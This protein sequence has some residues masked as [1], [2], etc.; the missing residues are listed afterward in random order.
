MIIAGLQKTTLIDYPGKIACV[1]FLA[2][3][4]FR[5]PWCYSS[6]LVLPLKIVKQPRISEKEFFD[7][8]KS[9]QGL[10]E[11]V[12]V[13]G[14]EPT[15]NKELAQFIEKIKIL[16]YFVK[17]DTN[18]SNPE[19]L[20]DLISKNL[21]DYVA[22]DIKASPKN[23]AYQSLMTEGITID[24][25]KES[26][27][28]LK[29]GKLDFEFRTTV[30]PTIHTK[31]DFLEI[32]KWIGGKNV[33]YYLQNFRAEKTI[34]PEFEKVKPFKKD[35]LDEIVKEISPYFKLCQLR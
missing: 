4:N 20:E 11:G 9:R 7:F 27:G 14:G 2:G 16:G 8:L 21:I 13:C 30:V 10:L 5:C 3:C 31:E 22:M 18:G 28:F 29:N 25:I 19:I 24:K 12:V 32:A 35:F 23:P 1:V 26:V 17:L 6:E 33:K 34:D 15:I